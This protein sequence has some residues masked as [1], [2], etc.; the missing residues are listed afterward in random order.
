[1]SIIRRALNR[2]VAEPALRFLLKH[3]DFGVAGFYEY[4]DCGVHILP[5]HY[6][7][8]IPASRSL[9]SRK[10]GW[11]RERAFTG[12][13]FRLAEQLALLPK[14]REY[15]VE[16]HH[17]FPYA[18]IA[19]IGYGPG[20]GET[21]AAALYAMIRW[22]R[23]SRIIEVGS[24]VST[25][26]S[27][28][29]LARN[30][31]ESGRRAEIICVEPYPSDKLRAL[32]VPGVVTVDVKQEFVENLDPSFF[33]AL[34]AD[35]ILFIDSSHTVRINGDVT[36]LYLDVLPILNRGVC[37]H[38][39]DIVFPYQT[40]PNDHPFFDMFH[41]WRETDLLHA[42]LINNDAFAIRLCQSYLHY[43]AQSELKQTFG[44]Y[45]A[46]DIPASIWL[47]RV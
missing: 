26:Y 18:E 33:L 42:F 39:H 6:Y 11:N 10:A 24:G 43:K 20:Y 16:C 15:A 8:P 17:Q 21:E 19:A 32:D 45:P 22:L 27:V 44:D 25:F 1:M 36:Y 47:Q 40:V 41:L 30:V 12:V 2:L 5:V 29:A 28:K 46:N 7:S 37:I 34:T 3:K 38:I 14:L 4:E 13:D 35:D 9:N 31:R 23:P